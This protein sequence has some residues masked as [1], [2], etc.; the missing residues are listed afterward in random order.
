MRN[1]TCSLAFSLSLAAC[2]PTP[3]PYQPFRPHS[4]VGIH[5]GYSEVRLGPDALRV[6]FHGNSMT[7]RDRVEGYAVPGG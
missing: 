5:G 4:A 7:S 2:A 3:T 1:L 6:R